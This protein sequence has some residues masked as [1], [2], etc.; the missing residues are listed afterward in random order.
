MFGG[1]LLGALYL[2]TIVEQV[3]IMGQDSCSNGYIFEVLDLFQINVL[4][5]HERL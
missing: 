2:S 3:C 4:K 5:N 1:M